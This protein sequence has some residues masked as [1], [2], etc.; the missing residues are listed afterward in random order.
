MMKRVTHLLLSVALLAVAALAAFTLPASAE[1][2]TFTVQLATG[3]VVT[4][5]VDVPPGTPLS[6]IELPGPIVPPGTP[7]APPAGTDPG[8]PAPG[9][10]PEP[11]P[12]PT[13]GAGDEGP[14]P[15]PGEGGEQPRGGDRK[16]AKRKDKDGESAPKD[17]QQADAEP[18]VQAELDRPKRSGSPERKLRN[19]DGSPAAGNPGF[20]DALPGP[21]LATGVPNFVIRKFR[22]P[23][24]LLPIYQA[25]GIQYG[26]RWEILAA[27]NEIETD[28][29]RNLNV[30]SAGALGVDAVHPVLVARLRGRRQQ[31]RHQ[32]PLQPRRRDLR[33]RALPQGS[34]L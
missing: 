30:S 27:I 28:Y 20:V 12:A 18:Q 9:P 11:A 13:P 3:E 33:R 8:T 10:A 23:V 19:S 32:G 2:R 16:P 4:I 14:A 25:A 5:T 21:S 6:D 34:R 26:V 7:S 1:P 24:F 17:R 31:G 29:G 22:V 15:K